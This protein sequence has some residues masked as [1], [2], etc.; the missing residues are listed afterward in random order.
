MTRKRDY[1]EPRMEVFELESEMQLLADSIV[2]GMDAP[3]SFEDGGDPLA[4]SVE[5]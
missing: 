4:D 5:P 3:G 2:G 1:E